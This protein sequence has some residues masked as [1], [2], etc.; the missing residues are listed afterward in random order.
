MDCAGIKAPANMQG[1]SYWVV[2]TMERAREQVY[3][4][5]DAAC[6]QDRLRQL[7]TEQWAITFYA[8]SS[9]GLLY[10]LEDDPLELYNMWDDAAHRGVKAELLQELLRESIRA[11]GQLP[12][13]RHP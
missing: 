8:N 4:E 2:L 6:L 12:I 5:C 1:E 9:H 11:D 3:I 13:S 7:R 10:N